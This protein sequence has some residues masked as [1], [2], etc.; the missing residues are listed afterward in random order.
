MFGRGTVASDATASIFSAVSG[1]NHPY[2]NSP[3]ANMPALLLTTAEWATAFS[4]FI[5][6]KWNVIS[7][8]RD[9]DDMPKPIA[10]V[11]RTTCASLC[12]SS[13]FEILALSKHAAE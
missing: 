3:S 12:V 4:P 13:I 6:A 5:R 9:G 1:G 8:V 10:T 11:D 7:V 2:P